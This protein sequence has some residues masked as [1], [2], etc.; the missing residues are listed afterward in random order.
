MTGPVAVT[1]TLPSGAWLPQDADAHSDLEAA[2]IG[3]GRHAFELDLAPF[4]PSD[5]TVVS[6]RIQDRDYV[7]INSHK[8]YAHLQP[9]G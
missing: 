2:G 7:L 4:G 8:T 1:V 9:A 6:V 5:G 3:C